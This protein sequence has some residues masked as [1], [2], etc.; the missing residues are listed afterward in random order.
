MKT[1]LWFNEK[2]LCLS[3]G[4]AMFLSEE[5]HGLQK[6]MDRHLYTKKENYPV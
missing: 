3:K 6:D 4:N 1:G 5:P 2:I